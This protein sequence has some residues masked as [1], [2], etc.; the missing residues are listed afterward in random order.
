MLGMILDYVRMK[1]ENKMCFKVFGL[2]FQ[3]ASSIDP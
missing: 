2:H 1:K 3:F